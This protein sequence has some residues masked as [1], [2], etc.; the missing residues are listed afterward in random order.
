[1]QGVTYITHGLTDLSRDKWLAT[2]VI[3][4]KK[5]SSVCV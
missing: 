3:R 2:W 4:M 5:H 1:M